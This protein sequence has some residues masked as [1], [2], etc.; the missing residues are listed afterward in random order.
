MYGF[1]TCDKLCTTGYNY[2]TYDIIST[3][4]NHFYYIIHL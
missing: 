2:L 4:I 1:I 3:F